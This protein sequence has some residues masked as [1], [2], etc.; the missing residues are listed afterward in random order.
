M[1]LN[2]NAEILSHKVTGREEL[3]T[4]AGTFKCYIVEMV[5]QTRIF[6]QKAISSTKNWYARGVG[7]VKSETMDE[8]GNIT[9]SQ[10]LIKMN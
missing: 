1:G 4:P 3:T 5:S 8:N 6:G 10:L 7:S 2:F 9:S